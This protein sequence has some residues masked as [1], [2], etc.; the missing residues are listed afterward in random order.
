MSPFCPREG[1]TGGRA[2]WVPP[3]TEVTRT[4][5]WQAQGYKR[6]IQKPLVGPRPSQRG[7]EGENNDHESPEPRTP[8]MFAPC[9]LCLCPFKAGRAASLILG[10]GVGSGR[11]RG[12]GS[13]PSLG[14]REG[15]RFGMPAGPRS[16]FQ[17]S[18][19]RPLIPSWVR[20]V[21]SREGWGD[22]VSA[23]V[24]DAAHRPPGSEPTRSGGW[25][26]SQMEKPRF[27]R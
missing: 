10:E 9:C 26:V 1:P 8:P 22:R 14:Q 6:R 19:H 17:G 20:T 4:G 23:R 24:P 5:T 2:H 12:Q 13:G 3:R 15:G 21:P 18:C 16:A 7:A 27:R 25:S 11:L